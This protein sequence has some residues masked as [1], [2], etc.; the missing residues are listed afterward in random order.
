MTDSIQ[1][2]NLFLDQAFAHGPWLVYA[3]LFAACFIENIFPPF[4]GDTFVAAAGALVAAG[5]LSFPVSLFIMMA[6]GMCS[7]MMLYFLGR[8]YGRDYFLRKN[9]KY[10]SALDVIKMETRLQKWGMVVLLLSR[11]VVGLRSALAVATG[12]AR[13]DTLKMFVFSAVSYLAF[14]ALVMYLAA[15]VVRNFSELERLFTA[16]TRIIWPILIGGAVIFTAHRFW[17]LHRKKRS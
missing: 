10:F 16:Y 3:V 6:G 15:S 14:T 1:H 2:I 11:F 8:N 12:L 7:I 4:P 13:Y 5:R 9:F 17:V